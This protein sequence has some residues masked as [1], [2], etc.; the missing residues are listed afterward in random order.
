MQNVPSRDQT[1]TLMSFGPDED[2]QL[3]ARQFPAATLSI[4]DERGSLWQ[5]R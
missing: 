4:A 1:Y 2:R 5:L 3:M